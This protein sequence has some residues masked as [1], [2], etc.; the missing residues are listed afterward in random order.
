MAAAT[1]LQYWYWRYWSQPSAARSLYRMI[2]RWRPTRIVELGLQSAIN[3]SRLV[4]IA[5]RFAAGPIHYVGIDPFE[6]RQ[7]KDTITLKSAH[8]LLHQLG[9]TSQFFPGDPVSTLPM[10]A[11]RLLNSDLIVVAPSIDPSDL[12]ASWDFWPRMLHEKSVVALWNRSSQQYQFES[13]PQVAER[14]ESHR[15]SMRRAA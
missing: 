6:S 11:N 7:T 9:A 3:T 14:A 13:L 4:R 10:V 12:S 2:P 5:Q 15:S 8:Q 1:Q